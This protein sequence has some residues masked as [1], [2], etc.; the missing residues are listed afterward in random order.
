MYFVLHI[1]WRKI[2]YKKI[3]KGDIIFPNKN[4]ILISK[5]RPYLRKNVLITENNNF[6]YTKAFIQIRPK[7]LNPK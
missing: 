4:S 6:F 2:G 5:I 3:E 1:R 7:L